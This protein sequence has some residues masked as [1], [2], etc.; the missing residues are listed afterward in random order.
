MKTLGN[1][2][3]RYMTEKCITATMTKLWE[4]SGWLFFKV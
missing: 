4:T 1:E 2:N 3:D